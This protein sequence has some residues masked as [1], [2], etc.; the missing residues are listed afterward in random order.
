MYRYPAVRD[1][2][3]DFL[4]K[5]MQDPSCGQEVERVMQDLSNMP[6]GGAAAAMIWRKV[7]AMGGR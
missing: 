5:H 7:A 1:A 3:T 2:Q 4:V 6:H